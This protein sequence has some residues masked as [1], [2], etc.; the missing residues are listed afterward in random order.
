KLPATCSGRAPC[1]SA[2]AIL[3]VAILPAGISTAQVS[4]ARAAYAAADADVLPV[5]A[6]M[7][8][9]APASTALETASVIPRSLNDPVGL[10]P[11]TLRYTSQPVRSASSGAGTSG[12]LPSYSVMI[13]VVSVTGSRSRYASI[14]PRHH[15]GSLSL[16]THDARHLADDV[17]RAQISHRGGEGRIRSGVRHHDQRGVIP[18]PFLP[19]GLNADVVVGEDTGDDG[20]HTGA[21]GDVQ[22]DVVARH[23]LS[24]RLDA[25]RRVVGLA[26][27]SRAGEPV[28]SHRNE[29]AHDRAGG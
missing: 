4:P 3:P 11:S 14:T 17:Q 1:T 2:C 23:H 25:Q 10:A 8:A 6:Q 22:G 16:Y 12:V 27:G 18:A 5:E 13:G 20:E 26:R 7:I 19:H 9:F 29:V 28:A 15:M 24:H 21:V